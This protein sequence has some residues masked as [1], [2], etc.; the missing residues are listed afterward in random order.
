M[1]LLEFEPQ[2]RGT[3]AGFASIEI[4]PGLIISDVV[5]GASHGKAWAL[6]PSKPMLGPDG[7]ALRDKGGKINTRR[8]CA[9]ATASCATAGRMPS[10]PWCA[11]RIPARSTGARHDPRPSRHLG[12]GIVLDRQQHLGHRRYLRLT[13]EKLGDLSPRPGR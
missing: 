9:G 3:R 8:S 11:R 13:L 12:I 4:W 6:L 2:R 10:S 1:R 7:A 5:V